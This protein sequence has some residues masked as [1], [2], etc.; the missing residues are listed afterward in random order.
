MLALR[1]IA[2]ALVCACAVLAAFTPSSRAVEP[3]RRPLHVAPPRARRARTSTRG[4]RRRSRSICGPVRPS[5]G[6]TTRSRSRRH[7][8]RS[9]QSR[10]L[11]SATS[12]RRTASGRRSPDEDGQV[13]HVFEGNLFLVG[14]GD[15]TLDVRDIDAL[16][17]KVAARGITQVDGRVLGDEHRFDTERGGPGWKPSFVGIESAP[18]SA[19][20]VHGLTLR[21]TNSSDFAAAQAFRERLDPPRRRGDRRRRERP[22]ATRRASA[23]VPPVRAALRGRP[24]DEPRERQLRRGDAAQRARSDGRRTRLDRCGE[25][26]RPG[27][28][29]RRR[30]PAGRGAT[31]R[32]VRPLAPRP[33]HRPR[34]R[35]HPRER[36][37]RS[38]DPGR[39]RL[40]PLGRGRVRDAPAPPREAADPRPR[41]GEDG[42]DERGVRPRGLRRQED[43]SSRSC[44]TARRSTTGRR[45]SR[46]IAS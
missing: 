19:L 21:N 22:R 8:R 43:T 41:A 42:D 32:R 30:G 17:H 15:P 37:D 31:R 6:R 12:G 45:A 10:S 18:L 40:L 24:R 26:R 5:T 23:R 29:R 14:S 27:R 20:S 25:A 38:R 16:A 3:S 44:R 35:R 46:R 13:G 28:A 36:I 7:R 2:G 11:L 34:A 39:L 33:A 9:S 4:G 1:S